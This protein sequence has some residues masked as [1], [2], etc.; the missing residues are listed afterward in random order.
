MLINKN[1]IRH[2]III[3]LFLFS[4][5]IVYSQ[6]NLGCTDSLACNY[7]SSATL[8]DGSCYYFSQINTINLVVNDLSCNNSF[9]QALNDGSAWIIGGSD[10]SF[11]WNPTGGINDTIANL[12]V[13]SY[14]CIITDSAGCDTIVFFDIQQPDVLDAS[15]SKTDISC[16]GLTDGIVTA[17]VS[18]GTTPYNYFWSNSGPNTDQITS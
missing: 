1:I 5:D 15:A 4:V 8:D 2:L 17:D 10:L 12:Q 3:A 16:F 11:L 7:D 18:G 13:G 14:N 9:G 6:N